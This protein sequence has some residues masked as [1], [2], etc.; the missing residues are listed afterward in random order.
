MQP[1]D[2]AGVVREVAELFG[3]LAEEAGRALNTASDTELRVHADRELLAQALVNLVDNALKYGAGDIDVSA[4][5]SGDGALISVADRGP[6]IP[7]EARERVL[8]RLVRLDA[9]RGIP[10]TGLGL[11]LVAAVARLHR[12]T[13]QLEDNA[14][15]LRARLWLA[16]DPK[17]SPPE[18]DAVA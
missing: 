6:G 1:I 8:G 17:R 15:G 3:P 14:P 12:G 18:H 5:H 2:V 16:A 4:R 7:A 11:S 9:S 13:L 10:G